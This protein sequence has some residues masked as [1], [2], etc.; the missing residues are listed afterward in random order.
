[1]VYIQLSLFGKTSQELL[2]QETGWISE[3]CWKRWERR[4]FQCLVRE[5]GHTLEWWE[6]MAPICVGGSW[7]PNISEAPGGWPEGAGSSSWQIL[8][9][10]VPGRYYL[11]PVNCTHILN[12]A[13]RAGCRPPEP[14]EYLL[15]RQGGRY[16]SSI[17]SRSA[18]CGRPPR[19]RTSK[20]SWEVLEGQMTLFLPCSPNP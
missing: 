2:L 4:S 9:E 12:L 11:N 18:V 17:P 14:I 19:D 7:T 16:P 10:N 8:E 15:L 20:N 6:G 5:P 3:P 13:A 1:M